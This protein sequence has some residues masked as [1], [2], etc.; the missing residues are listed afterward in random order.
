M[1]EDLQLDRQAELTVTPGAGPGAN[2]ADRDSDLSPTR[3]WAAGQS[4]ALARPGD[5]PAPRRAGSGCLG[6]DT[7][8]ARDPCPAG[9]GGPARPAAARDSES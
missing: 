9:R 8:T 3:R 7:V 2:L 6:P 4:E 1:S 5:A